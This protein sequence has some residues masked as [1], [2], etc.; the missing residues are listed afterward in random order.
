V[1]DLAK[2]QDIEK[3]V[4]K[5]AP[6]AKLSTNDAGNLSFSVPYQSQNITPLLKFLEAADQSVYKEW[7]VSQSTLEEVFLEVSKKHN[8][9]VSHRKVNL[10][11]FSFKKKKLKN[12]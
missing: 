9:K 6:D 2:V 12:I 7:G 5:V 3:D 10:N 11:F 4:L 1:S 8:F